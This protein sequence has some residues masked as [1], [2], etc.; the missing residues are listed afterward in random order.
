[1]TP[2]QKA[3]DALAAVALVVGFLVAYAIVT[4]WTL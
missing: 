1:M 2:A 4:G 3:Q